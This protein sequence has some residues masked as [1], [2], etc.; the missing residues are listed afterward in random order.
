MARRHAIADINLKIT[1]VVPFIGEET[2][3]FT[4]TWSSDI[5]WGEYTIFKN[6]DTNMWVADA[7]CMDSNEDKDFIKELMRLFIE[8]IQ[9]L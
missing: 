3:G 4:I 8:E 6:R 5:G 2:F 7:E 9:I 1:D